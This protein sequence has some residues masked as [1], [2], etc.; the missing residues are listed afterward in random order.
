MNNTISLGDMLAVSFIIGNL[1]APLEY[2]VL[3]TY[4]LQDIKISSER[5]VN[6]HEKDDETNNYKNV[7]NIEI[8]GNIFFNDVSFDYNTDAREYLVI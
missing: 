7:E 4:S 8:S 3:F 2:F 6:V 5:I 1:N